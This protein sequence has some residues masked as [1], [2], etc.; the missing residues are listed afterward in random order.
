[1][2]K[3]LCFLANP[4]KRIGIDQVNRWQSSG[5]DYPHTPW[6]TGKYFVIAG[7]DSHL[8][9]SPWLEP[10]AYCLTRVAES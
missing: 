4:E 8:A 5:N 10:F 9:A 1:M 7:P 3:M 6:Q 2:P